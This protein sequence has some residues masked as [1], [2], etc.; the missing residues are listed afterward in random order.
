[1]PTMVRVHPPPRVGFC[2]RSDRLRLPNLA[3][4]I[5]CSCIYEFAR[6]SERG[7][8]CALWSSSCA[9]QP[10][11][12]KR[13]GAHRPRQTGCLAR[14]RRR[15]LWRGRGLAP[16]RSTADSVD[17]VPSA[18]AHAQ[19]THTA[20]STRPG[21]VGRSSGRVQGGDPREI[22]TQGQYGVSEGVYGACTPHTR[23]D[24]RGARD[25]AP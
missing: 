17:L 12:D 19:G 5:K 15:A 7:G 22:R 9:T 1:M 2:L 6:F 21:R 20:S 11:Q 24:D 10:L 23:G 18:G 16:G 14:P 4:K 25:R 8:D 13:A 3:V